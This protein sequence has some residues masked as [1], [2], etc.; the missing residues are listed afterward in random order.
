MPSLQTHPHRSDFKVYF[1][2]A[3]SFSQAC[4]WESQAK[5]KESWGWQSVFS[6]WIHV[7][8]HQGPVEWGAVHTRNKKLPFLVHLFLPYVAAD[9][10]A[11]ETG[12][13]EDGAPGMLLRGVISS[14]RGAI[15][16]ELLAQPPPCQNK[17]AEL[18]QITRQPSYDGLSVP[19]L[20]P[21]LV[22][23]AITQSCFGDMDDRVYEPTTDS[24][25]D[26]CPV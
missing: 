17:R 22:L 8:V 20:L 5:P 21:S 10:P 6:L 11:E 3:L 15:S 7:A 9:K 18:P 26:H 4:G 13:E 16:A 14:C 25:T 2:T 12:M 24:A 23:T 1:K 19:L